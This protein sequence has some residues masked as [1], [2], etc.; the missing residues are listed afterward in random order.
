MGAGATDT[1]KAHPGRD[2]TE[3]KENHIHIMKKAVS[4]E[5][6][7]PLEAKTCQP[8]KL[9]INGIPIASFPAHE[10][11]ANLPA[12]LDKMEVLAG[13]HRCGCWTKAETVSFPGQ[14][15]IAE[16]QTWIYH[17]YD[18]DPF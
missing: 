8:S 4:A 3:T 10:A 9:Y 7:I 14:E 13:Y 18:S 17:F 1:K 12:L 11:I 15:Y 5:I 16:Q 2:N 6:F